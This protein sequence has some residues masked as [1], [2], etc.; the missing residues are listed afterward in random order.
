MES[1]QPFLTYL[2]IGSAAIVGIVAIIW[3]F[4]AFRVFTLT[5]GLPKAITEFFTL[6]AEDKIDAAYQLTT[7]KFRE[8]T[9]KQQLIKFIKNNKINQFKRSTMSI[10]TVKEGSHFVDVKVITNIGR[11]IPLEMA[12]IRQDQEWKIHQLAKPSVKK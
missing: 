8:Q 5:K 1:Y 6:I 7:E 12:F 9:S 11:E 3:A 10:P 2:G 4:L